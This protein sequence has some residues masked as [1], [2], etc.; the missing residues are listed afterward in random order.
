ML[1]QT[2][3]K[4]TKKPTDVLVQ[5]GRKPTKKPKLWPNKKPTRR[6]RMTADL[7]HSNP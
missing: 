6:A 4:P 3:R 5:T 1:V 7:V 2:G